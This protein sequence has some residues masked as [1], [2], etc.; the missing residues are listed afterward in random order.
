M[1]MQH[2]IQQDPKLIVLS[3]IV[4]CGPSAATRCMAAQGPREDLE[5]KTL[6]MASHAGDLCYRFFLKGSGRTSRAWT[7]RNL[8]I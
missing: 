7:L 4:D 3:V 5:G 1:N 6:N 2:V 8:R